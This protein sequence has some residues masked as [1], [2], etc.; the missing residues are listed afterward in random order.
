MLGCSFMHTKLW[1]ENPK[2]RDLDLGIDVNM[3]LKE[4]G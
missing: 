3:D 1:S 2:A 4:I